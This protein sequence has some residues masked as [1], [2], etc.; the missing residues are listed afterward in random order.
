MQEKLKLFWEKHKASIA[1]VLAV[2]SLLF[3]TVNGFFAQPEM[4]P[5]AL[6][7]GAT[8]FSL[9]QVGNGAVV[10]P[11]YSFTN[12]TDT[13]FYRIGANEIGA[14]V[15][16]ANVL[17]I[18]TGGLAVT[19]ILTVSTLVS[20]TVNATSSYI[21]STNTISAGTNIAAGGYLTTAQ[22]ITATGAIST[23]GNLTTAGTLG[24]A[25]DTFSG[26]VHFGTATF[27][28]SGTTI[29]HGYTSAP[30]SVVIV[31]AGLTDTLTNTIGILSI[32][33]TTFTVA[34]PGGATYT[35]VYWFAGK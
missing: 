5:L 25:T 6:G 8:N 27:V 14:S 34:V 17:D 3:N 12:D 4:A 1:A 19:G 24:I 9:V 32:G 29:A 15:N 18:E 16:G 20:Q 31:G 30:T 33:A 26:T 23:A 35:R 10:T 13:G 22:Q 2:L 28:V 21:T 7:G 11:A